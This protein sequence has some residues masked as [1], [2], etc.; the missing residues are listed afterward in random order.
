MNLIRFRKV[1]PVFSS[2]RDVRSLE[3]RAGLFGKSKGRQNLTFYSG[4][5]ASQY[6]GSP[7]SDDTYS[8]RVVSPQHHW[9]R[10]RKNVSTDNDS[11]AFQKALLFCLGTATCLF[12]SIVH[13][14]QPRLYV[15]CESP[16]DTP[17]LLD[18]SSATETDHYTINPEPAPSDAPSTSSVSPAVTG[19]QDDIMFAEW[20]D[21][22]DQ[23]CVFSGTSN[24]ELAREACAHLGIPLGRARIG[25][26]AD[27]EV[28]LELL[29]EVRGQHVFVI[30][31]SPCASSNH[32]LHSSLMELFFMISAAKRSSAKYVTAILPYASYFRQV[33]NTNCSSPLAGAD[34]GRILVAMGVDRVIFVD[35]HSARIEGLIPEPIPITN[36][37]PHSLAI[38]YL[39][40]NKD[41]SR[42]VVIVSTDNTG[43]DRA[44]AFMSRMSQSG[45]DTSM[46]SVVSSRPERPQREAG[47]IVVDPKIELGVVVPEGKQLTRIDSSD[48]DS[49]KVV[50]W[51]VGDV[52]GKDC[53]IVDDIIDTGER[54][55][56]TAN[57]LKYAG[58][59]QI[60]MFATHGVLSRGALDRIAKSPI[61][62]VIITDTIR[63]P[64]N[65]YC[66]KLRVI[67]VS[68][69]LAETIRRVHCKLPLSTLYRDPLFDTV[70]EKGS[71][72]K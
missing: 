53:I 30:Q 35:V 64:E 15:S 28:T 55:V 2:L 4:L 52:K 17:P 5:P 54:A 50:N 69:L 12:W 13:Q 27:G 66:Q 16:A 29:D 21:H 25:R 67:S 31:S 60:Y 45:F 37:K 68:R 10:W 46:A 36:L 38:A 61:K 33:T 59:R 65:L 56:N 26:F 3:A 1:H 19:T 47:T 51:L 42:R 22:L 44:E 57:A 34:L 58:A 63:L 6:V 49:K 70:M 41:L 43:T 23:L 39:S 18:F 32:S 8:R 11:Q 40:R 20:N 71:Y 24:P 7:L 48:M 9:V 62:E 72:T 14:R